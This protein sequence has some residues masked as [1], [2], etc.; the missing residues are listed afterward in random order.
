MLPGVH[1]VIDEGIEHGVGHGQPVESQVDVLDVG[2]RDDLFVMV[3]V[4]EVDVVGEPAHGEDDD[5]HDEHFDNLEGRK[6]L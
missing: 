4:D 1:P 2:L 3:G 5:H 6:K